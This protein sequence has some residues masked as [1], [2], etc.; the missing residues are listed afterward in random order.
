M[1]KHRAQRRFRRRWAAALV[2]FL[3]LSVLVTG[4]ALAVTAENFYSGTYSS[5]VQIQ[6]TQDNPVKNCLIFSINA[7]YNAAFLQ[8]GALDC[9]PGYAGD[10]CSGQVL[11]TEKA[12]SSIGYGY[13]CFPEGAWTT[14]DN[15]VFSV[16][17]SGSTPVFYAYIDGVSTQGLNNY[18]TTV[19][20][21]AW[22]E[23]NYNNSCSVDH[24]SALAHFT[25]W[26]NKVN[27]VF[28]TV[29]SANQS[30]G[31]CWRIGTVNNGAFN[32]ST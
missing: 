28:T 16:E 11:F 10:Q 12:D 6:P 30:P 31:N 25:G 1:S 26:L 22:A 5:Q 3:A 14:G 27:G 15:N 8:T 9:A 24:W 13:N 32:V 21:A 4:T 7:Q 2:A 19:T 23:N 20:F 18:G 29:T 17:R